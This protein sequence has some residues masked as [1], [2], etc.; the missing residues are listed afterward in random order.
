MAEES[1]FELYLDISYAIIGAFAGMSY[2]MTRLTADLDI[3]VEAGEKGGS[4]TAA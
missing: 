3:V 1:P 4:L 2:G